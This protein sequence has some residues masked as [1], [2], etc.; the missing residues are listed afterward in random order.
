M[1]I[2]VLE[3]P[4]RSLGNGLQY[5]F[6]ELENSTFILSNDVVVESNNANDMCVLFWIGEADTRIVLTT[7]V[8][9]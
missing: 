8:V 6:L 5:K 9:R 2:S 4:V 3:S 1:D 7:N